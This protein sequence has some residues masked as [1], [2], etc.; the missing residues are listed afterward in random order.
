VGEMAPLREWFAYYPYACLEQRASKAIGLRDDAMWASVVGSLPSYL[1][2]DGLARYFPSD[3]LAGSDV[4]TSYL[5]QI[6]DADGRELGEG[7]L[8]RMLVGLSGFA[9]GRVVRGSALPT[10]DLAIRKLAAIE[11]LAR[12]Q[13]ATPEMLDAIAIDPARWPT[14]ALIDWIGILQRVPGVK[15]RE[16][17]REQALSILRSR[18]NFQG[19]IMTFSTEKN[20]YLWWL[21]ASAD[22]NANRALIAI[23]GEES[24]KGDVGRMVRGAL[25]RQ[26]RGAW[27]TT[28][29]NAWGTVALDRYVAEFEKIP[30]SGTTT[31]SIG[32]RELPIVVQA[33]TQVV[34]IPWPDGRTVFTLAHGGEGAPWA[35]VQSRAAIPLKE[36]ISTGYRVTRSVAAVERKDASAW[37]R[38]DVYRVSL[39]ID[40]QSDM[41]WVVV[42]D[43]VPGGATILGGGLGRD[44]Q[45][46]T[47]GEQRTGTA[48]PSYEERGFEAFR[49]YYEYMPRGKHVVEYTVRL[50]NPG[51]F[52]LP[53]SRVEAM[54]A[55]ESFGEAPNTAIEV[56]P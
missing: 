23:L 7:A 2:G 39:E 24:W 55:P 8:D 40:A 16:T 3:E 27:S 37:T 46:A 1:D 38:G 21:M 17:R 33:Q 4:L 15:E 30:A 35:I 14:S 48:W 20:D 56:A 11:A 6:A 44:S 54:Y 12:H 31:A 25:S 49:A 18:L 53:P 22:V 45:I 36:P 32:R 10:A 9:T 43:P 28:V 50:N 19:T 29:A 52:A 47:R 41:T 13:R 51:R 42:S 34:D 26:L 5:V